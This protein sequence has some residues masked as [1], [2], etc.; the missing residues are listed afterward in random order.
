MFRSKHRWGWTAASMA[1][2]LGAATAAASADPGDPLPMFAWYPFDDGTATDATGNGFDGMLVGDP[3]LEPGIVGNALRFDGNDV[4]VAQ[5]LFELATAKV[6]LSLWV[7]LD[8]APAGPAILLQKQASGQGGFMVWLNPQSVVSFA[9]WDASGA[10]ARVTA[11]YPIMTGVWSHIYATYD[12]TTAR[13]YLH[14]EEA[15]STSVPDITSSN[16]GPFVIGRWLNGLMDEVKISKGAGNPQ[17]ACADALKLWESTSGRCINS[18][19]DVTVELDMGDEEHRHFGIC[20]VD[21]NHDG[22]VDAYYANGFENPPVEDTPSGVCPDLTIPPPFHPANFGT[23]YLNNGDGTFGP[24]VAPELG[25]DDPWNAMRHVW[26][27]YDNDGLRDLISHNFLVSNLYHAVSGPEV[28]L[29]E[30]ANE[31]T[32]VEI[33]ITRGTGA[34]WVDVNNDGWLDL[35]ACE[36]QPG[37]DTADHVNYLFLNNGNGTFTDIYVEAGLAGDDGINDDNPMGIVFGDYNNDGWQDLYVTN[38]FPEPTRLYR[39]EGINPNTGLPFFTD[40]SEEAGVSFLGDQ[41]AEEKGIGAGFGDFNNDGYLDLIAVREDE[42]AVYRNNGPDADGIWTFT[43]IAGL[44]GLDIHGYTFWGGNFGDLDNDGWLDIVITNRDAPN[45]PNFVA[46]N[47][48][49]GTW[50]EV[51]ELL[52]MDLPQYNGLGF[53]PA[54]I[55]ND[56]DLDVAIVSHTLGDPNFIFRNNERGNNWIQFRLTGTTSNL[57]AVGAKIHVRARLQPDEG[58]T[59]QMRYVV[60]GTGFFSD[61]PRIQT[62][63]L[64]KA[65]QVAR[66]R[67][68]WPSGIVQELGPLA[69]NQRYDIVEP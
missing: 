5:D 68:E 14:G 9:I 22:Y 56:G 28:L 10:M 7:K 59:T 34:S 43:D 66:V 20:M 61:V 67:I 15:G 49:D 27:D 40:V 50:T 45:G 48:R 12:G 60:A 2:C 69:V 41:G 11:P 26:G 8:E 4:V 54:D 13:L 29:F 32:G 65:T 64:G 30:I 6:S 46:L 57:D 3:Q 1:M 44:G 21:V 18:F 52:G 62:F 55:D 24:D 33:C 19:T 35:Y 63:G 36:W 51:G 39:N 42:S 38:T 37:E 31:E 25:I 17:C 53:V 23:F 47:N 16:G 58:P